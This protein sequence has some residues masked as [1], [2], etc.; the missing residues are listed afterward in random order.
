[1][2]TKTTLI[3]LTF[4]LLTGCDWFKDLG[5][6][7]ISTN[8][9]LDIPVV[10][11]HGKSADIKIDVVPFSASMDLE[12]ADNTDIEPYLAKIRE[13]DLKSLTVTF[14]GLTGS[15]EIN[16][17]TLAV[18]GVGDICTLTDITTTNNSFTPVIEE[19][20]LIQAGEKLKDD[21]KI[22]VTL[23]GSTNGQFAF[24]VSLN[25]D[26]DIVAGALD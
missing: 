20:L 2:K 5:E 15:Q 26:T 8:L 10:A 25:F 18:T 3:L 14:N 17:I 13:I 7:T 21:E 4:L 23:S 11:T 12:L 22:T 9:M 16:D 6:V 1:M 19:D 24:T